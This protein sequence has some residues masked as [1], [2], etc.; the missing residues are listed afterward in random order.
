M[1]VARMELEENREAFRA[2]EEREEGESA[3]RGDAN[4]G[5]CDGDV[6]HAEVNQAIAAA[7]K[8]V[9]F[10]E[11]TRLPYFPDDSRLSK[12]HAGDPLVLLIWKVFKKIPDNLREA[13]LAVPLSITLVR[14]ENLLFFDHFRRHQALHIGRRRRTIYLPQIL[15]NAAEDRGYDYWAIA[16]GVIYASWM[17]LDYLLLVEVI[18]AYGQ[19]ARSLTTGRLGELQQLKL[20]RMLNRHRRESEDPLRSEVKEFADGYKTLLYGITAVGARAQDR[21]DL[22]REIFSP[23]LEERWA[24]DKMERIA[25]I[26]NFPQMFLFDRDIIHGAARQIALRR[27]Q[28]VEPRSFADVLHDYRDALRFDRHPLMTTLGKRLVPKPR[29]VFMEQLLGL[30]GKGLRGFFDSYRADDPG[31]RDLMHPLWMYLC[32]LSSDP[33]GIFSRVGRCRAVGRQQLDAEIDGALAGI[34]VRLDRA[35]N[36][37]DMVAEV[38]S[39]GDAAQEEL[40]AL[41][42]V[43]RMEEEDDWEVFKSRKQGIVT[44]AC[45]VLEEMAGEGESKRNGRKEEKV[46]LHGDEMIKGLIENNPHRLTS[47]PSAVLMFVRAYRRSLA[48]FGPDDP[49]SDF[50]LAAVL[51]RLDKAEQ[52]RQLLTLIEGMGNPGFSALHNV[53]EQIPERDM[54]RRTILKEARILWSRML[55][56]KGKKSILSLVRKDKDR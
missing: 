31:V 9:L 55:A 17:L 32:T 16:E 51:I 20:I 28:E 8:I 12:L 14:D 30:G 47:D 24:R 52:Y 23:E 34:L 56:K 44:R 10:G 36:Y 18:G 26:F 11:Q 4:L 49:D 1:G 7:D 54:G 37:S 33:A 15:L 39:M 5:I 6:S 13:L 29:A 40:V 42:E 50:L 27:G 2:G 19:E 41:I 46:D 21:F 3:G 25:Q 48:E 38:V 22:A 43:Q 45:E 53:F 35:P